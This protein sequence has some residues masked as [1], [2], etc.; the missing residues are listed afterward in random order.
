M[1]K[2]TRDWLF[3]IFAFLFV[4]ITVILSLYATGYR[5]NLSWPLR[6]DHLLL[7]TG[8]LALDTIPKGATVTIASETRISSGSSL[9]G[10]ENKVTP[11]KIKN[12][13][14]GDY[15]VSFTL[16]NYWPYQKKLKV[17]PEQTT[18][19]ED[20]V[21]FRKSLP[22]N[23]FQTKYQDIFYSPNGRYAWLGNDKKIINLGNEEFITALAN[24]KINWLDD[25]KQIS[26]GAK[27][28][29]LENNSVVD[30]SSIIGY[31]QE[32][33]LSGDLLIYLTNN[34][35]SALDIKTKATTLI[36]ANG[37]VLSYKASG[38][39]LFLVITTNNKT[40]LKSFDL[41]NKK[42]VDS[43]NLL[44]SKNF[45]FNTDNENIILIDSEHKITYLIAN[46]NSGKIIKDIIRG[47]TVFKWLDS[48]K[49]AYA[50]ESEIY[51]YDLAQ[52]KSYIITRLSEKINSL[53][54]ST[55]NY[56]I[57][58]TAKV[59]GTIN[60]TSEGN[61]VTVLWQG[62][63]LSSLYFNNATGVLYFSGAIGQQSG[64]YKMTLK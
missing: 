9:F 30:Y 51:I 25:N 61:D 2:K 37:K 19:L 45:Y 50:N 16:D 32:S 42:F 5:F 21:L 31:V 33:Q 18:F 29:N 57:Y 60:L 36:P 59:I 53:A 43:A 35:L 22:L 10:I 14:P 54:W 52:T 17:Y 55:N 47:A 38:N 23:V 15:I 3:R 58:S 20:V 24:S 49:L 34:S 8:T 11:L 41:V 4:V 28:I 6:F 12:L 48:N 13:L 26:D 56:L 44:N 64:L 62:D 7:K 40:E 63:N 46:D 39:T 1:T 27:I